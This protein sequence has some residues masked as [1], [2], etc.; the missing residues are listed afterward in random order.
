MMML[1]TNDDLIS[2]AK[3]AGVLQIGINRPDK[4]NA[5][6]RQMYTDMVT[7][8]QQAEQD[9]DVRVVLIHGSDAC[10]TSGNDLHDFAKHP[11]TG[12]ESPVFQFLVAISQATKPLVAAVNGPAIGIGT[13]MLLHCDLVYAGEAARFQT[14]FV[15]LGLCP[16]AASS[17]LLPRLIGY[18]RAAE[19]LLLGQPFDAIKADAAGL[20]NGVFSANKLLPHAIKQA[21]LLAN[22][23]PAAVRLAKQ[24]MKKNNAARVPDII[25]EEGQLFME[26]LSSPEAVEALG[27]FFEG[28]P[29][30]FSRFC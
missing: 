7:A 12:E 3:E 26:R 4:L 28:R 20:V 8:L 10:F 24:L 21:Q 14:P 15:N 22:Q 17:L 16:E 9:N 6:T 11:P 30:D 2:T 27:A 13:T 25:A 19:M 1:A 18:P 23:P 5:I 29:A